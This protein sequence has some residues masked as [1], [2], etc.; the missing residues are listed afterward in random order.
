M[1]SLAGQF[2]AFQ[3][4]VVAVVLVAVAAVSVNQ[5]TKEF[6]DVRGQ[7]MIAVAENLASTPI[8]RERFAD[9][10]AAEILAPDVDRAIALSGAGLAEI[11]DPD[12]TVTVSSDP[13]R[14][15]RKLDLEDSGA[16]QGR[17][18]FGDLDV[19]GVHSLAGQ[20]PINDIDGAVLAVVSVSERYPSVW[21]LL[22]G[23]G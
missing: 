13:S 23:A 16:R 20:V 8:V 22:G 4:V 12:G 5:S 17:A 18:W 2:L 14:V 3:M 15:G 9:P 21:Q 6:R 10:F 11:A 19:D 1:R 7:R